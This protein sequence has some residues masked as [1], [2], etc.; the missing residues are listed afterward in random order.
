M[1]HEDQY[2]CAA[3]GN[4]KCQLPI[5]RKTGQ[6]RYLSESVGKCRM[7]ERGHTTPGAGITAIAFI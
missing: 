2:Y 5:T 3:I 6:R 7:L 4:F 1:K